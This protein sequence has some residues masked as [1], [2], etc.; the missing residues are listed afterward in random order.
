MRRRP[1]SSHALV[2]ATCLM[3]ARRCTDWST[4]AGLW[5][6]DGRRFVADSRTR[7][8]TVAHWLGDDAR[9]PRDCTKTGRLLPHLASTRCAMMAGGVPP[10]SDAAGRLVR[11]AGCA[12]CALAA[13]RG[14]RRR[15]LPP[16]S[17]WWWRRRRPPLRRVSGDVVTAGLISSRVWFGPVPGSP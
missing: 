15:S 5:R 7:R 2:C 14:A 3:A 1:S 11:R 10:R 13:R 6:S 17:S 12:R 4:L 16:R 9:W 8:R